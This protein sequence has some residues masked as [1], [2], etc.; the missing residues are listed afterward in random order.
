MKRMK[1]PEKARVS[2]AIAV[3]ITAYAGQCYA[4]A[5]GKDAI[6]NGTGATASGDNS[7]A[8]G[9]NADS[10]GARAAA[11][12]DGATATGDDS[13]RAGYI[14]EF[15]AQRRGDRQHVERGVRTPWPSVPR[16]RLR[17]RTR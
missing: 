17:Q 12:G 5:T 10:I 13:I 1:R 15:S 7:I 14:G 4:Q 9:T 8:V 16:P 2:I 6:A 11:L 3:A